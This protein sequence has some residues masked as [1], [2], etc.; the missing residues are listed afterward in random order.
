M[1][2]AHVMIQA[3]DVLF[4]AGGAVA[5]GAIA[6]TWGSMRE[7]IRALRAEAAGADRNP[8]FSYTL[9]TTES[10]SEERSFRQPVVS[11][12]APALPQAGLR[13]AA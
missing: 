12:R 1:S 7:S 3:L 2:V 6:L 13:A 11:L 8:V 9:I 10:R 4:I 5:L